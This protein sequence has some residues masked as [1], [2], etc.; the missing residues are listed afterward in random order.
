[1][2]N[3]A[4]ATVDFKKKLAYFPKALV[5][6]SLK[7]TRSEVRLYGVNGKQSLLLSGNNVYFNPGSTAFYML[8]RETMEM[9]RPVSKDFV[10]FVRLTDALEHIHAQS[11]AMLISD[12]PSSVA[13][14]IRSLQ[15][16][17]SQKNKF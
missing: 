13:D 6:K 12:V 5:K 2:L 4:G 3:E 7:N 1:M 14:R 10:D 8:D 16:R 9:R 17:S 11:T 15:R